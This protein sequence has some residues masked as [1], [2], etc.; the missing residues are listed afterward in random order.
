MPQLDA[1]VSPFRLAAFGGGSSVQLDELLADGPAV[2]AMVDGGQA[3][4]PRSGMLQE[5]GQRMRETAA[6]LVLVSSGESPLG[7]QLAGLHG[8]DWL[9]DRDGSACGALG[10]MESRRLG[11]KRRRDGVFVVD[12]NRMLRFAFIAQEPGQWIPASFVASRLARLDAAGSGRTVQQEAAP[13][14]DGW[15]DM[16][17]G[18][19]QMTALSRTVGARVGLD[20]VELGQLGT[21]A[22][23]RDLGMTLVP[24]EIITKAG[25]LTDEEW[26]VVRQHPE[27][28]AEML[29]AS[30]LFEHV[31]MIVR[32][33]H[34]HYDGTGYPNGLSGEDIPL[35]A[36]IL[37][38]VEA[39]LA[40]AAER[41]QPG[42]TAPGDPLDE[43]ASQAGRLYDPQVVEALAEVV[44]RA[45]GDSLAADA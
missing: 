14:Q 23:F 35:G 6:R 41:R 19:E 8:A 27:R 42:S 45:D 10:L 39:Y 30:R 18:E 4:D 43:L 28:S 29:G 37:L 21:A 17:P 5:L 13:T 20:D 44:G 40:L 16:A 34:E 7:R 33:S 31:R 15:R 9:T 26:H 3:D 36:R 38:A 1:V 2:L 22:R 24:D 12:R 32:A 25:P 11:R